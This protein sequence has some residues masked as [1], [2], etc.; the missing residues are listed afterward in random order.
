MHA[1][2]ILR[3]SLN[4]GIL[5]RNFTFWRPTS[6]LVCRHFFHLVVENSNENL[7]NFCNVAWTSLIGSG[8]LRF[9]SIH[10]IYDSSVITNK[11]EKN[12]DQGNPKEKKKGDTRSK[13][14][15]FMTSSPF[16][17]GKPYV[18]CIFISYLI[19]SKVSFGL[20][21]LVLPVTNGGRCSQV[22]REKGS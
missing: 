15:K 19:L 3:L 8:K 22:C 7:I 20:L 21:C 13:S 14:G 12:L 10:N 6:S 5:A 9:I 1:F 17:Y 11:T 2:C 4:K 16:I 18:L